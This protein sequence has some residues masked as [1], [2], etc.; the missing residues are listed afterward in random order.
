MNKEYILIDL[1][2][3]LVYGPYPAFKEARN[4]ADNFTSWEIIRDDDETL[5]D[6]NTHRVTTRRPVPSRESCYADV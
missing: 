6:W 5:V 4:R 3:D 2:T 1:C